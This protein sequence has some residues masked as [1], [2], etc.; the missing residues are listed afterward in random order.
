[1]STN[2]RGSTRRRVTIGIVVAV[3]LAALIALAV[4]LF[5]AAQSTVA[6]TSPQTNGMIVLLAPGLV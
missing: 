3:F 2:P 1:M 5:L 4:G 6:P